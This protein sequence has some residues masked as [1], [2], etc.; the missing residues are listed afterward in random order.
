VVGGYV[1]FV[2]EKCHLLTLF[3]FMIILVIA[4]E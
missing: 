2:G 3:K 1:P 4:S